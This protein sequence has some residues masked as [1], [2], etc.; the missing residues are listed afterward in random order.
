M[1]DFK[2][3]E[4]VKASS[5]WPNAKDYQDFGAKPGLLR[6][7]NIE[8]TTLYGVT[9]WMSCSYI[10]GEPEEYFNY[11]CEKHFRIWGDLKPTGRITFRGYYRE[12]YDFEE[13]EQYVVR[14]D[15]EN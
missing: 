7:Y 12:V 11:D 2:A 3:T 13:R 6:G 5:I 10:P 9:D 15:V 14:V 4:Y 8:V 1:F